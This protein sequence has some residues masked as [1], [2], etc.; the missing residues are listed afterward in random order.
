M[1]LKQSDKE[2]GKKAAIVDASEIDKLKKEDDS[3]DE[4]VYNPTTNSNN[5]TA[6][7]SGVKSYPSDSSTIKDAPK[8]GLAKSQ[9]HE[10]CAANH[11]NPP[12]FDCCKEEGPRHLKLFTFKVIILIREASTM[13][14][15]CI[16][17]PRSKKKTAAD[18]AAEGALWYLKHTGY[19][20]KHRK[21]KKGF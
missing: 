20:P 11:W 13:I 19:Q 2:E 14:L 18:D 10:I 5:S 21:N 8:T 9:L 6:T 16:G 15:E 4:I 1:Q 3:P 17:N 12:I 7:A